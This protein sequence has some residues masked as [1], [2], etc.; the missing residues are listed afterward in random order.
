MSAVAVPA[1]MVEQ[2]S[3]ADRAGFHGV[4]AIQEKATQL[5]VNL[6]AVVLVDEQGHAWWD[7]DKLP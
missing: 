3:D 4:H 5:G 2:L 6:R 7:R 1:W